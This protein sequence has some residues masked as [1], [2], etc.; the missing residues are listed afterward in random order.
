MGFFYFVVLFEVGGE[1]Y[2]VV[3]VFGLELFEDDGGV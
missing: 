3:V 2:Y 1:V